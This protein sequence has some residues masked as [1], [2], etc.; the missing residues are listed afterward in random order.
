MLSTCSGANDSPESMNSSGQGADTGI[1]NHVF[2]LHSNYI[3]TTALRLSQAR[4]G[5]S[6]Y[7]QALAVFLIVVPLSKKLQ[8][9]GVLF[10]SRFRVRTTTVMKTWLPHLSGPEDRGQRVLLTPMV[11]FFPQLTL[12]GGTLERRCL[13][14]VPLTSVLGV[15]KV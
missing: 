15:F 4:S 3:P 13:K 12:S 8:M 5:S 2:M 11:T 7:S 10:S 6:H 9:E 14:V 1:H